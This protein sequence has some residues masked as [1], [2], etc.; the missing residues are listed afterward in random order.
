[1]Q[2]KRLPKLKEQKVKVDKLIMKNSV[3]GEKLGN[4]I[5]VVTLVRKPLNQ[6]FPSSQDKK[7]E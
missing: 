1:M 5:Q 2:E 6:F 3:K 4:K 7:D